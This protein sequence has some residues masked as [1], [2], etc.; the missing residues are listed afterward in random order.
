MKTTKK[1]ILK[2]GKHQFTPGAPAV[3][4][5]DNLTDDEAE[6]YIEKFPR[7]INLF[8]KTGINE[9]ALTNQ[10]LISPDNGDTEASAEDSE[11][12]IE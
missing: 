5:N 9:P 2:P 7:I 11:Q 3:H 6:W 12:P 8:E 10:A 4:T 1:Y